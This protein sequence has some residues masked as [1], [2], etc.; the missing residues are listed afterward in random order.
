MDN[1]QKTSKC[2]CRTMVLMILGI[3][4]LLVVLLVKWFAWFYYYFYL[5]RSIINLLPT[6]MNLSLSLISPSSRNS[7]NG[8]ILL[9]N[10]IFR[11][12]YVVF[13]LLLLFGQIY[14]LWK[15]LQSSS[16][17]KQSHKCLAVQLD[18]WNLYKMS[19]KRTSF[20]LQWVYS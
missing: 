10:A 11:G 17:S 7:L 15:A 18:P 14:K 19:C 4:I 8:L 6:K 16:T 3:I 9:A 5:I 1:K 13:W 20:S 12:W 2:A